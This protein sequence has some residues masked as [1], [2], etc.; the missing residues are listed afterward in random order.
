MVFVH[1]ALETVKNTEVDMKASYPRGQKMIDRGN[2]VK[3]KKKKF[4]GEKIGEFKTTK[5]DNSIYM[6][7]SH[8]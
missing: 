8:K 4:V 6:A 7:L 2:L 5:G 1:S 3:R